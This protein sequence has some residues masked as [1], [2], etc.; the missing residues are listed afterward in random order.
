MSRKMK[1]HIKDEIS[2]PPEIVNA[3]KLEDTGYNLLLKGQAGVGKTT[4]AMSLLAFFT[5][6]TPVYLSTRVAPSS[7]YSQFPWLKGKLAPENILDA[8]RTYIPPAQDP[9]GSQMK[10]HL[11]QT[12]RFQT[13]PEFLKII[14][15]KVA[16][17]EH[18]IIVIDSWDAIIG[19]GRNQNDQVETLFTEFIRQ[20]NSKLILIAE[21]DTHGFLD[22]IVDGILTLRDGEIAGRTFRTIEINKIRA[23]ERKQKQYAFT[24]YHNKFQYLP[25]YS[26]E[27]FVN[28]SQ[29]QPVQDKDDLFSTG[30][31]ALDEIYG[32]GLR[33][34]TFNL[35]EVESNVPISSVSSIFIAILCQFIQNGRGAIIRASDGI[36]SDLLD[37]KRLFLYLPTDRISKY[38]KILQNQISDRKE[39]RPYI[40]QVDEENF[41]E[42]FFDTYSKLSSVSKFQPVFAGISYDNLQFMVD[43]NKTIGLFDKHLKLIR[44]SNV[45]ELGI[46]NSSRSG[47]SVSEEYNNLTA[48]LS[49]IATTHIKIIEQHGAI[50]IYSIKP[51]NAS[52]FC[53]KTT[54]HKGYPQIELLP[55][56]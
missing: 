24:L 40:R 8:T 33:P 7:L 53:I 52:L 21:S 14:Y 44:N 12:I 46:I 43:F 28:I 23:V 18:P 41:N 38:M 45:I 2:I 4:F 22:Y 34:G 10:E 48:D 27:K 49:Y 51:R 3:F 47:N 19:P 50:M 30:N 31:E 9:E 11:M 15:E 25:P 5:E 36:N 35:L 1:Q 37:K 32:G 26:K 29:Y 17:Y 13:I 42:V 6:Y 16:Q 39:I 55:I 56:V 20:S 54:F